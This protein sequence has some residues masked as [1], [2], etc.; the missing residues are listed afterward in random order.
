MTI[1]LW[2]L[3][4]YLSWKDEGS[5][6]QGITWS[7]VNYLCYLMNGSNSVKKSRRKVNICM[8]YYIFRK[9]SLLF[10]F[11]IFIWLSHS[12][13]SRWQPHSPDFNHCILLSMTQGSPGAS[14]Q[15]WVSKLGWVPSGVWTGNLPILDAMH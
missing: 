9:H 3:R 1:N 11:L 10:Y 8:I 4:S 6:T 13:L 14:L 2:E 5:S 15:G 12:Q 7:S